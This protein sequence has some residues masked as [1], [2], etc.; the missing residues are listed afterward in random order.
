M[1]LKKLRKQRAEKAFLLSYRPLLV[2]ELKRS[3][4]FNGTH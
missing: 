3:L 4:E 1:N 2:I